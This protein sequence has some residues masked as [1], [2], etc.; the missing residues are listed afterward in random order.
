MARE[1]LTAAMAIALHEFD[2]RGTLATTL[3]DQIA[4]TLTRACET[5]GEAVL[6]VSGGT[7][8]VRLF[9]A[10]SKADIAWDAVTITLVD[11]RFVPVE[12][13][14]SNERL[15][16]TKLLQDRA[17]SARFAGLYAI[18]TDVQSAAVVAG[19]RIAGLPRPFDAVVLGMGGD[20]HTASFFPHGDHL[21]EAIDP[22]CRALVLPMHAPNAGEPRLTLT[23]P[24]LIE[25]GFLALHIE[26]EEKKTALEAALRPGPVTE[27][28]V[29]AVFAAA[30]RPVEIFWAP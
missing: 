5:R 13:V 14:R 29:R 7:T 23:L 16:R 3:A 12:N 19:Q 4:A 10:L 21:A 8:P 11:E 20:G 15:V 22:D 30:P 17:A 28:P 25:A 6:A 1:Q 27:M 18:A 9:E 24:V 26:G 2:D